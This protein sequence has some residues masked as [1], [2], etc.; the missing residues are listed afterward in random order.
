[1]I[2]VL[3]PVSLEI[4]DI[5][6]LTWE[7]ARLENSQQRSADSHGSPMVREPHADQDGP[8]RGAQE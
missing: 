1:M 5:I 6:L 7:K 2:S 4:N 8:E 3:R